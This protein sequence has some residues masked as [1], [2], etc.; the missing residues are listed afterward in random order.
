MFVF[1]AK[2]FLF[3]ALSKSL[4]LNADGEFVDEV[5][6]GV[7]GVIPRTIA[8]GSIL[9]LLHFFSLTKSGMVFPLYWDQILPNLYCGVNVKRVGGWGER[10]KMVKFRNGGK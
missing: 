4:L 5:A 7:V 6:L 1:S 10:G 3:F 9:L 8:M 2:A